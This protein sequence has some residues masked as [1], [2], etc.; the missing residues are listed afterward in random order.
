MKKRYIAGLVLVSLCTVTQA[1]ADEDSVKV[2]S[3]PE[4]GHVYNVTEKPEIIK[5]KTLERIKARAARLI[6]ERIKALTDNREAIVKSKLTDTQ[7]KS[8]TDTLDQQI[9]NMTSLGVVVNQG[10]DATSTRTLAQTVV[11]DYRIYG[12]II[13]KVRLE[14]RIYDLQNYS[15]K[16]TNETFVKIQAAI[17]KQSEKGKDVTEWQKSLDR[18][19]ALVATDNQKL[20]T[21]LAQVQA[22]KPADYGTSS[23]ATI[24]QVNNDLKVI[25][26][27]FRTINALV[28]SPKY[29]KT[30]TSTTTLQTASS[31]R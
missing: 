24:E 4:I 25:A 23:K 22:L 3:V 18:A 7:K 30:R 28:K 31:T 6:K 19:K 8:L 2:P 14:R 13:P 29:F 16:I 5:D 27:D 11:T 17:T 12:I 26:K 10:V 15:T 9:A 21:L 1:F 20:T